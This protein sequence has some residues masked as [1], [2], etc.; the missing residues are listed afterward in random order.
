MDRENTQPDISQFIINLLD[1]YR[2]SPR[3]N[4]LNRV[5]QRWQQELLDLGGL[6]ILSG[7]LGK[8]VVMRQH[9]Y[10]Q[11]LRSR[12]SGKTWGARIILQLWNITRNMWFGR[13]A[14]KHNKTIIN[15]T[16]GVH[17]LDI[18]IEKEYDAGCQQLPQTA[19]KWFRLP[20]EELLAQ[21]TEYK[22]GWLL[23]IKSIKESMK[24]ADHGI[25]SSSKTLW[26]WIGL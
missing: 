10:Y 14:V 26:N 22:K 16:I 13:N 25:F 1:Q 9:E 20:K 7:L 19:S 2:K 12:K 18:E 24:V 17:L 15:N 6:N 8:Q 11:S 23:I 5:T 4:Q 21:S 3:R